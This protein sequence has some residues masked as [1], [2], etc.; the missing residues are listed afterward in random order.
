MGD[1]LTPTAVRRLLADHGLAPRRSEGQNFLVD[2][3]WADKIVR[4]AGIRREDTVLE[5]GPGLGSL[6]LALAEVARAVVAVEIDAG[7]VRA[8]REVLAG[9]DRV[10]VVHA[11]ALEV[12][13]GVLVGGGPARLVANLPYHLATPMVMQA[14]EEPALADLFVMV[15][16]EVGERWSA[17]PGDGRYGGVTVRLALHATCE[18]VASV[19]RTVFYPVPR[20]DSVT[21][22]IARRPDAPPP[23]ERRRIAGVVDAAFAHRRKTLRNAL[24]AVAPV[25]KVEAALDAVGIDHRARAEELDLEAFRRLTAALQAGS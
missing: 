1:R 3:N 11:D 8:L 10:E 13:L 25:G 21:V 4:D 9:Q 7:L 18:I 22:R 2:P 20:V 23:A 15:Q 24:R 19:P 14:V 6:T 17:A 12:D 5:I 16:R